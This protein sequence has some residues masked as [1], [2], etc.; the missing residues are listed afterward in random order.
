MNK[1]NLF[2]MLFALLLVLPQSRAQDMQEVGT[3]EPSEEGT[4]ILP[5]GHDRDQAIEAKKK[6]IQAL[7]SSVKSY[8]EL[9]YLFLE[10]NALDEAMQSFDEALKLTPRSHAAKTGK[11]IVLAGK[12]DLKAA[13]AIF[14]E[15]LLLNPD[16]IRT[17]YELGLVYEKMG[18]VEK[19]ISEFKKGIEKHTQGRK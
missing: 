16:P 18:D 8:I 5:R 6:E 7:P 15:A 11:G 14:K 1:R 2:I 12:G 10:K 17:H 19:A 13:E 9:G 4:V 3:P